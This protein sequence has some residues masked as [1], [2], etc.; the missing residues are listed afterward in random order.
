[1]CLQRPIGFIS[2][3]WMRARKVKDREINKRDEDDGEKKEKWKNFLCPLTPA[4]M[5]GGE[6]EEGR[7][8]EGV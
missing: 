7:Y 3:P 6:E 4:C 8:G 2:S 5:R 1:M